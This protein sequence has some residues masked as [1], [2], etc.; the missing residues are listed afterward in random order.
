MRGR[1]RDVIG[2]GIVL[3]AMVAL[4]AFGLRSGTAGLI[5]VAL[6]V[7]L[8]LLALLSRMDFGR[9]AVGAALAA[10]GTLTW[11]GIYLGPER[12]GDLLVLVALMFLVLSRPNEG[13]VTPPW[14]I[15]QLAWVILLVMLLHIVFPASE[16]YLTQRIV[17]DANGKFLGP[18][19]HITALSIATS[20]LGVAF[21][22]I[23]GIFFIPVVFAG[24]L[25]IER[26]AV[27]WL[28][29]AFVAG[30]AFNGW[31]ATADRFLHTNIA[32][33]LT[34]IPNG[35]GRQ[36]GLSYHP[37]FLAAGL[38]LAV[39]LAMY[40]LASPRP[41]R[42]D[43]I[44]GWTALPGLAGG[45]YASGS[46]GGTVCIILAVVMSAIVLPKLRPYAPVVLLAG[47]FAGGA[48]AAFVPAIGQKILEVTRLSGGIATSGSNTVRKIV[49]HQ[50]WLDFKH[51]PIWG[52]DYDIS[53]Q[54]SQVYLQEMAA[55]G[56]LLLA[57]M[58]IY[59]IAGMVAAWTLRVRHQLALALGVAIATSLALNIF[60]AD[61]T[62]RF[63]YVPPAILAALV[64]GD[65]RGIVPSDT[66][67]DDEDEGSEQVA[68]GH[69][70]RLAG[71]R[72]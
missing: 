44:V 49:A 64:Y 18:G 15:K 45:V 20:D 3:L 10:A 56:L 17:M 29:L 63:Y 50:G 69:P 41:S 28:T 67:F 2:I 4:E 1:P 21:K 19:K 30:T 6:G 70:R 40:L 33:I 48:I 25:N 65:A 32:K 22:F 39:P 52:I 68:A 12:P 38:V 53:D 24:I 8:A 46:R 54:A 35:G 62:D 66:V 27:H 7:V 31:V 57:A 59:A 16:S 61:L 37:N 43:K 60:E 23:V 13:F 9:L 51:S 26:R 11:N 42:L 5:L 47:L 34:K 72:R 55:G 71:A 36:F 58:N 14:W